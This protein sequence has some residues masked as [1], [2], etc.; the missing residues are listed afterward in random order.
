MFIVTN[1]FIGLNANAIPLKC[2]SM[3][4]QKCKISP[5]IMN[6]NSNE[7]LSLQCSCKQ[8]QWQL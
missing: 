7:S 8:I 6:I 5:V 3:S 4:D 2:V 1:G